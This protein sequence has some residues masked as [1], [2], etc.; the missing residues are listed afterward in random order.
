M[1]I[2]HFIFDLEFFRLANFPFLGELYW[3][4]FPRFIVFLFLICVGM[5]LALVHKNK[6]QWHLVRKRFLKL[7]AWAIVITV[8]TYILLPQNYIFFGILHCIATTSVAAVFLAKRPK[9]CLVL[10]LLIVIPALIF[11]PTLIPLEKWLGV[12]PADYIPF[13]PWIGIVLLGIFLESINVHKIPLKRNML[14][15][16]FEIMGKHSLK[17]Y[18]VHQ[19]VLL[20]SLFLIYKL[21]TAA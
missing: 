7:G 5:G 9:L 1:I 12:V 14:T 11:K 16:P 17:I 8:V 4:C 6:I 21:K 19:P 20:G 13:Y 15:R 10:C 18:L 3:M 2:F